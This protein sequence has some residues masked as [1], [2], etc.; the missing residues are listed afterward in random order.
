MK[1]Y[2]LKKPAAILIIFFALFIVAHG[3]NSNKSKSGEATSDSMTSGQD[4]AF[5]NHRDSVP[6]KQQ[7]PDSLFVLSH[8]YPATAKPV[9]NPS[10]QKALNG[11]PI[12]ASNVFAYMDSLKKYVAP[13]LLPFFANNKEWTSA[14]HGWFNEPWLGSQREAI[15]GSYETRRI[16]LSRCKWMK[17]GTPWFYMTQ[18]R[19]I[20]L[21]KSGVRPGKALT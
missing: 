4:S 21:D 13:N 10:W 9:V 3:C 5:L 17:P 16:C 19:P 1:Q 20:P 14:K 11:Q 8:D 18:L 6:T 15:L 12:S 7:Y 2:S